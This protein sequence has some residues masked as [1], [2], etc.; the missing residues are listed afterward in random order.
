MNLFKFLNKNTKDVDTPKPPEDSETVET[1]KTPEDSE[2]SLKPIEEEQIEKEKTVKKKK[3]I[4]T[5]VFTI[6]TV[7]FTVS[8]LTLGG[9][10]IYKYYILPTASVVT[11][12]KQE[13][14]PVNQ[15]GNISVEKT[16]LYKSDNL[17]LSLEYPKE[18][19]LIDTWESE[20]QT[21]KLEIFFSKDATVTEKSEGIKDSDINEGYIFRISTFTTSVRNLDDIA[22]IKKESVASKCPETAEFS[23]TYTGTINGVESRL[24]EVKNCNGD[25]T[26]SYTPK[27]GVFYAFEQIYK[28]DIGYKQKQKAFTQEILDSMRFYPEPEG[29]YIPYETYT[30]NSYKFSFEHPKFDATCCDLAGPPST[31]RVEKLLVLAD[32]DTFVSKTDFDG[33]ALYI[34]R[35]NQYGDPESDFQSFLEKQKKTLIDD[36]IVVRGVQPKLQEVSLKLGDKDA[37]LLRGYSWRDVDLIYADISTD[38]GRPA[39]LIIS[40]KR[41]TGDKFDEKV[42]RILS[43]FKFF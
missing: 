23:E 16:T 14:P 26:I 11:P 12:P 39:A 4:F 15:N 21:K 10:L 36:Y 17:K 13:E 38:N 20:D 33:L 32:K 7:I 25:M 35:Y 27:F 18:A 6:F 19:K 30:N 28:G 8:L 3:I 43:S 29:P 5:I 34:Y 22:K 9:Y 37:T 1:I 41:M 42:D 40:V 31:T 2:I 24:F